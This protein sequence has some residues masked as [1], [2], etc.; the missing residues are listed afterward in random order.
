MYEHETRNSLIPTWTKIIVYKL[1]RIKKSFEKS[2]RNTT[3]SNG[4]TPC[5]YKNELLQEHSTIIQ[6]NI[7]KIL[8]QWLQIWF[9]IVCTAARFLWISPTKAICPCM[10]KEI[11]KDIS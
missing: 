11:S 7:P 3:T 1:T 6:W 4:G 8:V 5:A 10:Y 2:S 9:I